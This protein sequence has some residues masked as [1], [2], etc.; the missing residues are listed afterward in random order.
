MKKLLSF[1][2]LFNLLHIASRADHITGGE[3]SYT[4]LGTGGGTN[5]Y[6][7]IL[8]LYMRCNS[9]RIFNNPTIISVFTQSDNSRVLDLDVPLN[10]REI[11]SLNDPDP[12]ISNPPT[13]CYEV[14]FYEF[15]LSLPSS[16]QGYIVTGQVN[17]RVSGIANLS[18]GYSQIGA[19]YTMEIPGTF[20]NESNVKN[21]SAQ[22]TG[23]DLVIVCA[24]NPFKYSFG[25]NDKDADDLRYSFCGAYRSSTGPTGGGGNNASASLPP[26]YQEVPYG[27]GFGGDN[28]LG[29]KVSINSKTGLIEGIAP[30]AGIYVVTV[31]VEEIRDGKVI[32]TQRKDLQISITSCSLTAA[33]LLPEYQLCKDTKTLFL[34][35]LSLS[36]L[37]NA[38]YWE[39]RNTAGNIIH[40][41]TNPYVDYTFADTGI[42]NIKL[43][44]NQGQ[45]CTDSTTAIARVYPGFKPAYSFVGICL[46]KPT[47]FTDAT[48]SVYGTVNYWHWEFGNNRQNAD[49]VDEKNPAYT[50][51]EAGAT[52]TAMVVA[53]SKGCRDTLQK[54]V[55]VFEKPP[56]DLAFRDTLICPPDQLQLMVSGRGI[57]NWSPASQ[58]VNPGSPM[59][60][61]APL[62]T[63]TYYVDLDDDGC[64]NRDSVTIRVTDKVTLT[65]MNDT[66]I[67]AGDPARLNIISNALTYSWT[68][69]SQLDNAA[70][71]IPMAITISDTRYKIVAGISKCLA[72]EEINISTVPYPL[73]NAGNDTLICFDT[74]AQLNGTSNGTTLNWSPSSTLS[75]K[76]I[77]NPVASPKTQT[78]YILTVNSNLGCPKPVSDSV[79]ITVLADIEAFAGRDTSLVLGESLQLQ[80]EGGI[81]YL[82][83]P[84]N[85]LSAPNIPNPVAQFEEASNAVRYSVFV[86]NEAGC[87]DSAFIT[88][89]VFSTRPTVFVPTG[90]TPN[91]DGNNDILKPIAAGMKMIERFIVY[92]RYGQVVFNT[93]T[94]GKGWDGRIN[95]QLQQT[96]TYVWMVQAVDYTGKKYQQKGTATLIR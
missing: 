64:L 39:L 96:S 46:G 41:S 73:V 61:V 68:P 42:Y 2:I 81:A 75:N 15:T 13:V 93:S 67:C 53:D 38:Y 87:T 56:I 63:T 95:G 74:K 14:G 44:I 19:S 12:C 43:V 92:N 62:K 11:I 79:I 22:F 6:R 52:N 60:F 29:I 65:A 66:T 55:E 83:I 70:S 8:K 20:Y 7:C 18:N 82:W 25:A 45:R 50:F 26:P 9:G 31:C 24:N 48:T 94:N 27:N 59:P 90:F 21:H 57:F 86:S 54:L 5:Q 76:S 78:E 71:K 36:T 28:P 32:A 49:T 4:Y 34:T 58:L 89:K 33:V 40:T 16:T 51:K 30:S 3:M 69:A 85:G 84:S 80:A 37:I 88:I 91:G 1:F 47:N 72:T 17:F 35:N 10:R 77:L 23:S